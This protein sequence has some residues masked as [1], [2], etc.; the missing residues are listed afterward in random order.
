MIITKS[1]KLT[2]GP[3]MMLWHNQPK[4]RPG[5]HPARRRLERNQVFA[6]TLYWFSKSACVCKFRKGQT[7]FAQSHG[8]RKPKNDKRA[9]WQ[10]WSKTYLQRQ[11]SHCWDSNLPFLDGGSRSTEISVIDVSVLGSISNDG[12]SRDVLTCSSLTWFSHL[13]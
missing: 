10:K 13:P 3:L 12:I 7:L 2:A 1:L 6:N 11:L 4:I 8:W 5:V 9:D